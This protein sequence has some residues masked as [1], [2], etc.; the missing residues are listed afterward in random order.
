MRH[1][2]RRFSADPGRGFALW[3]LCGCAVMATLLTIHATPALITD[4]LLPAPAAALLAES[5]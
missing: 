1:S 2:S 4:R 5:R 3:V